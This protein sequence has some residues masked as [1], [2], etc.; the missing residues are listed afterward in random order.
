VG[1][2]V[3][4]KGIF[5]STNSRIKTPLSVRLRRKIESHR[6][7]HKL[8]LNVYGG[9]QNIRLKR[10][11][12]SRI[13]QM[14]P[15]EYLDVSNKPNLNVI[16]VVVD[17]LRNSCLSSRG[18]FRETTPFLD[19]IQSQFSAISASSWTYP[20]VASILTGLFPHNHNAIITGKIKH[21]DQ[22]EN[23][24]KLKGDILTL[25]E[26][27]FFLGYRIY[28]G[29]AID[30]AFYPLRGR[31]VP[32]RYDAI[33]QAEDIFNDLMKW[34]TKNKRERLFAYVHLGDLHGPLNP[35]D[36][37]R[38]YFGDVKDLPKIDLG[39]SG[40]FRDWENTNEKVREA[41]TENAK[42]LYDN[43]LRYVD[44]EIESLFHFLEDAG[45]VDSTV[46]IITADH[47]EELGEHA[48]MEARSFYDPRGF[49]GIGHGHSVFNEVIEVPLLISGPVPAINPTHFVSTVDIMPTIIDLLEINHNIRFD[50]QSV[51]E[52]GK[53]RILLNEASG[54]GYEKKALIVGRY[55]LIYSKDDGVEWLFDLEKD[56]QEQHPIVDKEVTS[57][58][59]KKGYR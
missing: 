37:F 47:G 14:N 25:P 56:P 55:K 32:K 16:I 23:F 54:Y 20:S 26:M 30:T 45:L 3:A 34:I 46:F 43:I 52:A 44:G 7:A 29:T 22:L 49:Y 48:E 2:R 28:F 42:L 51:F 9:Y 13:K 31:V 12:Q 50:G 39:S 21:F 35:P 17:A 58:S 18:Y 8:A 24:Q 5:I 27:L 53:D 59:G 15:D 41:Y 57:V 1:I 36:N 38:N 10:E 6:I 4:L 33:T 11:F 19:S 40:K